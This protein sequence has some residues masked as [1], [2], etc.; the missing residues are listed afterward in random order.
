MTLVLLTR[1]EAFFFRLRPLTVRFFRPGDA[2]MSTIHTE[3]KTLQTKFIYIG[4]EKAKVEIG[5]EGQINDAIL[6]WKTRRRK[7]F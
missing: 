7:I 5:L 1:K 6:E 2:Q 4:K 3:I